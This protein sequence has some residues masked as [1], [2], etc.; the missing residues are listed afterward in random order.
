MANTPKWITFFSYMT[1]LSA[2]MYMPCHAKAYIFKSSVQQSEESFA[3][4]NLSENKFLTALIL[5]E[6]KISGGSII[7]FSM[8][9]WI[10]KPAKLS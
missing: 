4:E 7:L 1:T 8:T 2:T 10:L 3:S 5:H 6:S 9:S